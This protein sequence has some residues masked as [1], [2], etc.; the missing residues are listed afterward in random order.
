M[1]V[2]RSLGRGARVATAAVTA[3]V[4]AMTSYVSFLAVM[5]WVGHRRGRDRVAVPAEPRHTFAVVVPAHDEGDNVV[6]TIRS[7]QALDYPSDRWSLHVVAD[8][9]SDDTATI[10]RSTGARVHVRDTGQR[11]KGPA[12][13]WWLGALVD[14]VDEAG[15]APDAVVVIDADTIVAADFLRVADAHLAAGERV[16]QGHYAV[17]DPDRSWLVALRAAALYA[18]HYQRPL[19]RETL[20]ASAGLFGNGMVISTELLLEH[21][22]SGH[23]VE[24]IELHVALVRA[25][26]RVAFA[27]AARVEAEMP[28]T[29]D[30]A[31]AQQMRWER[32]RLSVAR[33]R[34]PELLG[35][36]PQSSSSRQ[37]RLRHVE[38]AVDQLMPPTSV[39]GLVSFAHLVAVTL[40]WRRHRRGPLMIAV[41]AT[42]LVAQVVSLLGALRLAK[43][44]RAVYRW[45]LAAPVMAV[46]KTVLYGSALVR[47]APVEWR[48]TRRAT[49]DA[50]AHSP[51]ATVVPVDTGA[52]G[53]GRPVSLIEGVL[54]DR[55]DMDAALERIAGFVEE[56]RATGRTHQVATVNTDYLVRLEPGSPMRGILQRT[57][58]V[59]VDGMPVV[60]AARWHGSP[61]PGRV[62]G[63]DM[64]PLLAGVCAERGYRLYLMGAAPGVAVT[65]AEV[66]RAQH[67]ALQVR[68]SSCPDMA[69]IED[70]DPTVLADIRE[71]RADVV[72]VALGHP[73]QELWIDRY[74]A[75]IDAGVCIGIGGTLDFLAGLTRRAP[76]SLQRMGLEWSHRLA[77]E[78][79]RLGRRYLNDAVKMYRMFRR[80]KPLLLEPSRSTSVALSCHGLVVL[81]PDDPMEMPATPALRAVV[82]DLARFDRLDRH[83]V[84]AMAGL[85]IQCRR[86]GVEV[87]L[88]G[89]T[90]AVCAYL[91]RLDVD[92]LFACATSI[93]AVVDELHHGSRRRVPDDRDRRCDR[94]PAWPLDD[95]TAAPAPVPAEPPR[96]HHEVVA[97]G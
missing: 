8:H 63:A 48:R 43:A 1:S 85:A 38:V 20:G 10:A 47:R 80:V 59:S 93:E 81:G 88:V 77:H 34:V 13:A 16:I 32:G 12:I 26:E 78:P 40:A 90:P 94:R 7:L 57:D 52:R 96:A 24:D 33:R 86:N 54:L 46:W 97:D 30:A 66:L 50:A 27:A 4:V 39:L 49:E 82:I 21:G 60:W 11:G 56:H 42:A 44:P 36:D 14:E 89:C 64:V 35:R 76:R 65:A 84:S 62:T 87:W 68:A 6:A 9:C 23:L 67:P 3:V 61:V 18:R 70:M 71:W 28:A 15:E 69:T 92:R 74:G 75:E 45:L 53:G 31:K 72:L 22:M 58:L 29:L 2:V 73:K 5:A 91:V 83:V 17:R 51:V 25:G 37:T 41:A 55:V 19:G 79:R 95:A